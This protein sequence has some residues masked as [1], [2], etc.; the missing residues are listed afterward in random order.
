MRR[1][2]AQTGAPQTA[3]QVDGP[4]QLWDGARA[5]AVTGQRVYVAGFVNKMLFGEGLVDV[6]LQ[7][8]TPPPP[9]LVGAVAP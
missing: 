9:A 1:Y 3:V 6:V 7:A 2:D 4:A 5:L 8:Y